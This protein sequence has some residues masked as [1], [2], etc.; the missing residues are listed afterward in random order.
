[1]TERRFPEVGM[2]HAAT[3]EE[4]LADIE[5]N[6]TELKLEFSRLGAKRDWI[7]RIVGS[8]KDDPEFDEILRLGREIRRADRPDGE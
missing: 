2:S 8:F 1:M 6:V 3:I 4:R 5:K 7:D